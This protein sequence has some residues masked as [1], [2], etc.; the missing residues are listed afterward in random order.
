[1][2]FPQLV[3]AAEIL[4]IKQLMFRV[5]YYVI[6]PLIIVGFVLALFYFLWG[7]IDFLKNRQNAAEKS[8]QGKDHMMYGIFGM[9]IMVSAFA[10]MRFL[11]NTIGAGSVIINNL[12]G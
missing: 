5:S 12:P 2:F 6:N 11:A 4:S 10:I 7:M 3:F 9:I 8:N 1:M